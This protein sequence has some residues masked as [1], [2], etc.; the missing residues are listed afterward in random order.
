MNCLPQL[1]IRLTM[2][3]RS[4]R[5]KLNNRNQVKNSIGMELD[6]EIRHLNVVMIR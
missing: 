5:G 3:V 2:S 4:G 6:L 1:S